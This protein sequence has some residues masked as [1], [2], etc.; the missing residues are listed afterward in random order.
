[1]E[2]KNCKKCGRVFASFGDKI[3]PECKAAED[4]LF[5]TVKEYIY[6]H[7]HAS[8]KE[9]AEETQVE[10]D[11]ILRFLREGRIEVADDSLSTL[12]CEKCGAPVKSG[13]YCPECAKKLA[14]SMNAAVA[15]SKI[16]NEYTGPVM[17]TQDMNK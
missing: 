10:E 4:E 14:N 16:K 17:H 13:R 1:M 6:D 5:V 9:I 2:M 7:P 3:C 15:L 8:I 11:T 12:T